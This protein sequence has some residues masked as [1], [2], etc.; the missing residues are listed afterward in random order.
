M[1]LAGLWVRADDFAAR[2]AEV[3]RPGALQGTD[4]PACRRV[5]LWA[6]SWRAL[7][8]RARCSSA[9]GHASRWLFVLRHLMATYS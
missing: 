4:V 1:R 7:S 2:V 6:S 5:R 9:R 3:I 8:A